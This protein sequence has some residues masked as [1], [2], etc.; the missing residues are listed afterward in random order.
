MTFSKKRALLDALE[1]R[2][3]IWVAGPEQLLEE[4]DNGTDLLSAT[5]KARLEEL[6]RGPAGRSFAAARVLLK[7]AL[8]SYISVPPEDWR[9]DVNPFGA[10]CISNH[11]NAFGLNVNLSKARQQVA[12][13]VSKARCGVDIEDTTREVS[14]LN[15]AR[16]VFTKGEI[17]AMEALPPEAQSR[18]FFEIWCLK[19]AFAKA[20]GV[21]FHLPPRQI[22]IML[23]N[24]KDIRLK[25]TKPDGTLM[26]DSTRFQLRLFY[27]DDRHV[28]AAAHDII[29]GREL[30][31]ELKG[32]EDIEP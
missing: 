30:G 4:K 12:C 1:D 28:I 26:R 5:E 24:E 31:F 11:Q 29:A 20:R 7:K 13:I 23:D 15:D 25:V 32:F 21:G 14:P 6:G 8:S 2:S 19:E 18:Q 9:I 16:G 27:T 3:H 22:E 17:A 10:L